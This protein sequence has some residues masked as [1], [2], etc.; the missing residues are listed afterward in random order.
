ML[1]FELNE[2]QRMIAQMI[3]D[4]GANEITPFRKEWDDQSFFPLEY[5]DFPQA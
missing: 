3:R 5:R 4:F 2:N 1:D